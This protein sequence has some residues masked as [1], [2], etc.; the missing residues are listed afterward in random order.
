[1]AS[2]LTHTFSSQRSPTWNS[3]FPTLPSEFANSL[4]SFLPNKWVHAIKETAMEAEEPL[5]PSSATFH[6]FSNVIVKAK[7][8][9]VNVNYKCVSHKLLHKLKKISIFEHL[10]NIL[11]FVFSYLLSY[12]N[13][14]QQNNWI[15][16]MSPSG[17]NPLP[18]ATD[19]EWRVYIPPHLFPLIPL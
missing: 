3:S 17:T 2:G 7:W 18:Q 6:N 1:M 5:C 14:T 13:T 4:T 12:Q 8:E 16:L 9:H 15:N 11:F 19:L 10:P